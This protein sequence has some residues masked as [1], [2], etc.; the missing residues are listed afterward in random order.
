MFTIGVLTSRRVPFRAPERT[1][2]LAS[3]AAPPPPGFA[4]AAAAGRGV[5]GIPNDVF[6]R[7]DS[8][9]AGGGAEGSGVAGAAAA[10]AAAAA[11]AAAERELSPPTPPTHHEGGRKDHILAA[12]GQRDETPPGRPDALHPR[13]RAGFGRLGERH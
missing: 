4:A 3:G 7:R 5:T 9:P 8:A 13:L 2:K 6:C 12:V 11:W 1:R 10:A